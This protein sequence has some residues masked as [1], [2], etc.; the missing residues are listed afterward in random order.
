MDT[1]LFAAMETLTKTGT[2]H[3]HQST[4][5][6]HRP[7]TPSQPSVTPWIQKLPWP[8]AAAQATH[9]NIAFCITDHGHLN[10]QAT[11]I[12][13]TPATV[14]PQIPYEPLWPG[15]VNHRYQS[16]LHWQNGPNRFLEEVQLRK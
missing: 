7:Q 15:S 6:L 8:Y 10:G 13:Q 2:D 9:I 11:D 4:L 3:G 16:G 12:T 1:Y 5:L 14:R